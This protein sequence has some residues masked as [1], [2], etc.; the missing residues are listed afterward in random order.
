MAAALLGL[1]YMGLLFAAGQKSSFVVSVLA[2]YINVL[3]GLLY[4]PLL[5]E[6]YEIVAEGWK[7]RGI[8]VSTKGTSRFGV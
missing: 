3:V 1:T 2:F 4:M 5:D 8:T 7:V 6:L